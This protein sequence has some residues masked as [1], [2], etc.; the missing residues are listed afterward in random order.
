MIK[1]VIDAALPLVSVRTRDTINIV[2]VLRA[3]TQREPIP[4]DAT[5]LGKNSPKGAMFFYVHPKGVKAY[6]GHLY[7]KLVKQECTLIVV[8]PIEDE[9]EMFVAGEL[10]V[11]KDLMHKFMSEVTEDADKATDLMRG[12]G[13]V[14]LKEAAELAMLTMARDSSLTKPGIV[15]TRKQFFQEQPGLTLVDPAQAFYQPSPQ[16]QKWLEKERKFFFEASD[17]R[18]RPRGLMFD[19]PP[20]VGKTSGAKYLAEQ[21]GVPLYRVDIGATKN[22]YVGASESNMMANIARLDQEEPCIALFDEI[23]KVFSA[24]DHD[25]SG[26]T[27]TMMSQLLWWL[28]EHQSR[29]MVVMTT[30]AAKKLPPELYREGRIDATMMFQGL[31]KADAVPFVKAVAA[32]FKTEKITM[33]DVHVIVDTAFDT[34]VKTDSQIVS[35]AAL[36]GEVYDFIKSGKTSNSTVFKLT[37]H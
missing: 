18:L 29:V 6:Y 15:A 1:T 25:S 4:W 9:D 17:P 13:G 27:T 24:H 31:G 12:L 26:T 10:P 8:N 5:A 21:W 3:L 19:G 34:L 32:T 37:K 30:N 35:Q 33:S 16:L 2:D 20:G 23:E 36:T 14:T 7:S 28:A 22:K 11:P